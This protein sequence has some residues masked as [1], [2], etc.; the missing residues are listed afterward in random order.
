[1]PRACRSSG[2]T[3][4]PGA[5]PKSLTSAAPG[6]R[7]LDLP[8]L[9]PALSPTSSVRAPQTGGLKHKSF[10]SLG[11]PGGSPCPFPFPS[12]RAFRLVCTPR[13]R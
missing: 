7:L 2:W 11:L 6:S 13:V 4:L 12:A 9:P 3:A 8:A 1:M 10:L 5:T